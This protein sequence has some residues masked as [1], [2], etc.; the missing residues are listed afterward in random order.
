MHFLERGVTVIFHSQTLY[1]LK[2][3]Y[4]ELIFYEAGFFGIGLVPMCHTV[5]VAGDFAEK[6]KKKKKTKDSYEDSDVV[7]S[8]NFRGKTILIR[9]WYK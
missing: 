1:V 7:S 6:K 2:S 9:F 5:K 3:K 4:V 8:G